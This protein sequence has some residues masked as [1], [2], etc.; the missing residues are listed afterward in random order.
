MLWVIESLMDDPEQSVSDALEK[1]RVEQEQ[2]ALQTEAR[3]VRELEDRK[4]RYRLPVEASLQKS[5]L[6]RQGVL[7][8]SLGIGPKA[9]QTSEMLDMVA[10]RLGMDAS[11]LKERYNPRRIGDMS[12]LTRGALFQ[13][14]QNG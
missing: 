8:K 9:G 3:E 14:D 12:E 1:L 10:S 13:G 5:E 2:Q 4:E 11:T 6:I 7:D